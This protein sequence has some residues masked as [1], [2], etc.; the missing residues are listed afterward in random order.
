MISCCY[1]LRAL[2]APPRQEKLPNQLAAPLSLPSVQP[3]ILKQPSLWC[4]WYG[5]PPFLLRVIWGSATSIAASG[6]EMSLL[7]DLAPLQLQLT[8]AVSA[9]TFSKSFRPG[10]DRLARLLP[11]D[12]VHT[13]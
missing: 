8:M 9:C 12:Q 4:R 1:I 11:E 10:P 6:A 2:P 7:F 5:Y 13:F 3:Q